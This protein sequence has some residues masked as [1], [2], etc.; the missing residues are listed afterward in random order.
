MVI[1]SRS[2]ELTAEA[3]N[4]VFFW[5][6]EPQTKLKLQQ[7]R[8][9]SYFLLTVVQRQKDQIKAQVDKNLLFHL[10]S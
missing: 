2:E 6:A 5:L 9:T 8:T 1:C 7:T 3:G 10:C 4:R